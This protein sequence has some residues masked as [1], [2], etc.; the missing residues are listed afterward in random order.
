MKGMRVG[1]APYRADLSAPGDRRR[2]PHY[3]RRR[4]IEFELAVPGRAYDLV[5]LSARAD[6]ARWVRA[7]PGTRVVFD[8]IDSYLAAGAGSTKDRL[9]G[10]AKW[11]TGE[12]SR[13]VLSY[14]RAIA[15]MAGRADA[16]V[17]STEEQR[18]DLLAFCGNVHVVL[19]FHAELCRPAPEP[20]AGEKSFHLVW[21]GLPQ[22]LG[23]FRKL[24]PVLREFAEHRPVVLHVVTD[25]TYGRY[26]GRF[27]RVQTGPQLHRIFEPSRLYAWD[28]RTMPSIVSACD[29]AVIPL[30]DGDPLSVGKPENKLLLFWRLGVP[31]LV[32]SSPAH[33]RAMA[34]AGLDMVCADQESWRENLH[35]LAA[36]P[37]AR[38]HAGTVGRRF[39]ETQHGEEAT[40]ERWDRVMDSLW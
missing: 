21:E 25:P 38:R 40:L 12:L 37:A 19:D 27:P 4:G 9:R 29:L 10:P 24:A 28:L 3:A 16:V 8:L 18:R 34:G 5:V 11:V 14:R 23:P 7:E 33:L 30:D 26:L 6:I 32:S 2:F 31:A 36:D 35:R 39:A 1:Y 17:C 22:N 13:P 15:A 20:R